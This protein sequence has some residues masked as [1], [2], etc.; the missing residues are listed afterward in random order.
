MEELKLL[1]GVADWDGSWGVKP[2]FWLLAAPKV[3]KDEELKLWVGVADWDGGKLLLAPPPNVVVL[4]PNMPFVLLLLLFIELLLLLLL[5]FPPTAGDADAPKV[6]PPGCGAAKLAFMDGVCRRALAS[7]FS[8]SRRIWRRPSA[9]RNLFDA[10]ARA[11][12][13]DAV[14]VEGARVT[15]G[16]YGGSSCS[17]RFDAP[18]SRGNKGSASAGMKTSLSRG[19]LVGAICRRRGRGLTCALP[20]VQ[21]SPA[22]G[23]QPPRRA[24]RTGSRGD[25]GQMCSRV[26]RT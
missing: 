1:V 22:A 24:P 15:G 18:D 16:T 26:C 25:P 4:A 6:K 7:R 19:C 17:S 9:D 10:I 13:V 11:A 8:C 3:G 2:V 12:L 20:A 14:A 21:P 5:S 23:S